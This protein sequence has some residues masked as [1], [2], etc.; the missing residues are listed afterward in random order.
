MVKGPKIIL[1]ESPSL[2]NL[3]SLRISHE[4]CP[5]SWVFLGCGKMIRL[6]LERF[7][8]E[9]SSFYFA[10]PTL[11][12]YTPS[13]KSATALASQFQGTIIKDLSQLS[14][15]TS[16]CWFLSPKPQQFFSL[17]HSLREFFQDHPTYRPDLIIS[18][19]A[20]LSTEQIS[21]ALHLPAHPLCRLMPNT[22]VRHGISSSLMFSQHL[23]AAQERWCGHLFHFW[24]TVLKVEDEQDFDELTPLAGSGPAYFY[25]LL[26]TLQQIYTAKGYPEHLLR[27]VLDQLVENIFLNVKDHSKSYH[28]Q[29]TLV[30][31]KAGVT[32]S[33]L[34]SLKD[35]HWKEMWS[36]SLE[37]GEQRSQE[38]ARQLAL[39]SL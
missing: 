9:Q 8:E 6:M 19:M 22:G 14:T 37:K 24:G 25:F 36:L 16:S 26:E 13:G 38:L 18:I 23:N 39:P 1:Q 29:W 4:S 34:A 33:V 32:E 21:D 20:C 10:K 28:D 15:L 7:Q 12:F 30:A 5:S 2:S 35:Q 27:I 31:S 17:A 11:Y 3:E